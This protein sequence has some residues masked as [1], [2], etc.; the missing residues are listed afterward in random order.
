MWGKFALFTDP[1]TKLGGE[2]CSYQI[3]TY[4][5]IKGITESI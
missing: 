3:P 2:K 1:I 5:A 4:E